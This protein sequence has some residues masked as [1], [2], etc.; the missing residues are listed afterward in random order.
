MPGAREDASLGRSSRSKQFVY[1][2]LLPFSETWVWSPILE[3]LTSQSGFA[4]K[5]SQKQ[6][7]ILI[8]KVSTKS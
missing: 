8:D 3:I 2:H 7:T 6:L 4:W 1:T 5:P